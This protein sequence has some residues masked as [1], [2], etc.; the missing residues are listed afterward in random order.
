MALHKLSIEKAAIL[1][2]VLWFLVNTDHK[3]FNQEAFGEFAL[4]EYLDESKMPLSK[5]NSHF[6]ITDTLIKDEVSPP[7]KKTDYGSVQITDHTRSFLENGGFTEIAKELNIQEEYTNQLRIS[8]INTNDSIKGL[9]TQTEVFY[10][11]QTGFNNWQK[12]LTIAIAAFTLAQ[13]GV[14]IFKKDSKTEIIQIPSVKQLESN[15]K[16]LEQETKSIVYQDSL[17]HQIV[18]DSLKI[19]K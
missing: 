7:Y 5:V 1:D 10:S 15:L 17:F 16:K 4:N 6:Y 18:K 13:V 14:A 11:K 2:K 12:G 3:I 8:T 9:N 19:S